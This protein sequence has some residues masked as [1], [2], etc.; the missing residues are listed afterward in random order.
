MNTNQSTN[1]AGG[2]FL[3]ITPLRNPWR[4][5]FYNE[6]LYYS[7]KFDGGYRDDIAA[8][9]YTIT[10]TTVGGSYLNLN[11]MVRFKYPVGQL[12]LYINGGV[13]NSL[14]FNETNKIKVE[15][16]FY[17]T[18]NTTERKTFSSSKY[19]LGY[20]FGLGAIFKN[21]S[22]EAR[23]MTGNNFSGISALTISSNQYFVLL[24]YRF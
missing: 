10:N 17:S 3:E 4:W 13:S 1:V 20:G 22:L 11:T 12:M 24:G 23:Y 7:F 5:S 6:L 14:I 9:Q 8:N 21:Y 16:V 15:T 18:D 2:L 19:C